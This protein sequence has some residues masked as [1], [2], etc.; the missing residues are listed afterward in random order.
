MR[1]VLRVAAVAALGLAGAVGC[2]SKEVYPASPV[3][4]VLN[5]R[6]AIRLAELYLDDVAPAASMRDVTTVEP[7]GDGYLVGF[8][9]FFNETQRAPKQSRL[10]M[11]EHD[12]DVRE[13]TFR[14]GQ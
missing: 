4:A 14:E 1:N 11:V 10:V 6:E 3:P 12:G 2:A 13:M 9:T 5:D 7:T 8:K